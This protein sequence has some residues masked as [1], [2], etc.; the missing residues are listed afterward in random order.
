MQILKHYRVLTEDY[1]SALMKV[2]KCQVIKNIMLHLQ[3][4]RQ[5]RKL[6]FR[7]TEVYSKFRRTMVL[8]SNEQLRFV[9][10]SGK[11]PS[12]SD[13]CKKGFK[14]FPLLSILKI[15]C[16]TLTSNPELWEKPIYWETAL[17]LP[18]PWRGLFLRTS[19]HAAPHPLPFTATEPSAALQ[20]WLN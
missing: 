18:Q 12:G 14:R 15:F 8:F 5:S 6:V 1:S 20:W 2:L 19:H 3:G 11:F 7:N 16:C 13:F 9:S 17:L 4:L 10:R